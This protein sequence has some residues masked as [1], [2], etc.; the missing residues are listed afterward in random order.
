LQGFAEQS[1]RRTLLN[2]SLYKLV[3]CLG[4]FVRHLLRFEFARLILNEIY[5]ELHRIALSL[6]LEITEKRVG[7]LQC[8]GVTEEPSAPYLLA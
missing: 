2:F 1:I 6:F 8:V 5:R 7:L 3:H 4:V